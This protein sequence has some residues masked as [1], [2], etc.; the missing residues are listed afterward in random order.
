LGLSCRFAGVE[1]L[2]LAP[3]KLDHQVEMLPDNRGSD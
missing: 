1:R 3:Q 2:G